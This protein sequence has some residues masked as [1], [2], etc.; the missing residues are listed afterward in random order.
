MKRRVFVGLLAIMFCF[1]FAMSSTMAVYAENVSMSA[2]ESTFE[3]AF[4]TMS[5]TIP[6]E[7]LYERL[8]DDADLLADSEESQL[9][10]DL[11]ACSEEL[12]F[13]FVIVTTDSL[14]GKTSREYADD[15][16]D[17]GGYGYGEDAD[18]ILLLVSMEERD[19]YISTC[20]FG[21]TAFSDAAIDWV[22]DDF[23]ECLSNGQYRLAFQQFL[24]NSYILAK[25]AKE[26]TPLYEGEYYED[27]YY[28]YYDSYGNAIETATGV[29]GGIYTVGKV[30]WSL[31][32]GLL[33]GFIGA[34]VPV[35]VMKSKMKS[36][37][38]QAA[39]S[40]YVI[41]GSHA[42]TESKDQF[43]YQTVTKTAIPKSS[44]SSSSGSRSRAGGGVHRSSSGRSHGGRGGKF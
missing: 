32:L 43:L 15:F 40:S 30:I 17:Y 22:A 37:K 44:S 11:D 10:S 6:D 8:V 12:Q 26:G 5:K 7:R 41:S 23:L 4:A 27:D 20:G 2:S 13:D 9:L 1:V 36:V 35:N 28:E 18:G 31:F 16:Y 39:A 25:E 14:D 24:S 3:S 21:I 38:S 33:F 42:V 29:M 19:W 34:F